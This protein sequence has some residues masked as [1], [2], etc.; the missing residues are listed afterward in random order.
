MRKIRIGH[1]GTLH[2]HSVGKLRCLKNFPEVFEIVGVVPESDARWEEIQD[3]KIY[4]KT[5]KDVTKMTEEELLREGVDAVVIEGHELELVPTAQ[6]WIERG[7]HV[8]MDK[9][10]G[11]DIEAFERLMRLAESKNLTVQLAYMY[12]YNRD[13]V[14]ILDMKNKG[15]FGKIYSVEA[16][17]NCEHPPQKRQWLDQF[18]GGMMFYL[19]CHL[20][21]LIYLLQGRPNKVIPMNKSTGFGGVTAEDFGMAILEYDNGVSFAKTCA[22]EVCGFTRRQLAVCGEKATV[23]LKPFEFVHGNDMIHTVSSWRISDGVINW[24]GEGES[25]VSEIYGRYD[26]MLMDFAKM[27]RGEKTN[28]Y[29]Y[30]Y[31]IDVHKLI[32]EACG[33]K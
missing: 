9:P 14:K 28:P 20:I 1:I 33:V 30:D 2:D 10:A 25:K 24:V 7:V 15:E 3:E 18:P 32:L 17:M 11:V 19:G 6:K 27:V 5:Y 31:E 16:Q 4:G 29:T 21:D 8:H 23:E 26:D 12:R 13:V 22:A